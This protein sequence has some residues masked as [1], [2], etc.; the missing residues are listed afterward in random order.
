MLSLWLCQ[1][2]QISN[3]TPYS[4]KCAYHYQNYK[5][6]LPK[7][8][9][10]LEYIFHIPLSASTVHIS[11]F[12]CGISF[13]ERE[14]LFFVRLTHKLLSRIIVIQGFGEWFTK[15][16]LIGNLWVVKKYVFDRFILLLKDSY[17]VQSQS[18]I[19]KNNIIFTYSKLVFL[20]ILQ[21]LTYALF[22]TILNF[23]C[24][25]SSKCK[26]LSYKLCS[27]A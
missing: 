7:I 24:N 8:V 2:T 25:L 10:F 9:H 19:L 16:M 11:N 20:L 14:I 21:A 5:F 1:Q 17:S 18:K 15:W 23:F 3:I 26:P 13:T 4:W 22:D 27:L 12:A 6:P